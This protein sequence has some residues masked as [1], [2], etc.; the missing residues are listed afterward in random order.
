MDNDYGDGDTPS[1]LFPFLIQKAIQATFQH[2]I[3]FALQVHISGFPAR[4]NYV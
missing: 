3:P 2:F 4:G 1:P